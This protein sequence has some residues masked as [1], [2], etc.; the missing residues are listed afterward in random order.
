MQDSAENKEFEAVTAEDSSHVGFVPGV[1]P[2]AQSDAKSLSSHTGV[3]T[4]SVDIATDESVARAFLRASRKKQWY[5]LKT[6][7]CREGKADSYLESQNV[8]TFC[9]TVTGHRLPNLLFAYGTEKELTPLVQQNPAVPYLR[10]YCRYSTASDKPRRSL[11]VVPPDQMDSLMKICAAE[12]QDTLLY[13]EPI[14]KFEKGDMARVIKGPF[15]GV[16]GRVARFKGQQRVGLI[17]DD[18]LTA[19]TA[20]VPTSFLEPAEDGN[21]TAKGNAGPV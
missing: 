15:A 8:R 11:I 14:H 1:L 4:R 9:P 21:G 18:L 7:Y 17:I 3:S 5:V 20:Y 2:E 6:T 13:T 12:D 16:T 19:V 10:F